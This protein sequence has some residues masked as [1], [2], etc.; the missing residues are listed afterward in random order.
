MLQSELR[1]R[2]DDIESLA[3]EERDGGG[4]IQRAIQ[5]KTGHNLITKGRGEHTPSERSSTVPQSLETLH[6]AVGNGSDAIFGDGLPLG[7]HSGASPYLCHTYYRLSATISS[8]AT[9]CP[10]KS[11]QRVQVTQA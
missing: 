7:L 5:G 10:L 2:V 3:A 1:E 6:R 9:V 8:K 11:V 4:E